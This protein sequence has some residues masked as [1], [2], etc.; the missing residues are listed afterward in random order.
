MWRKVFLQKAESVD[1]LEFQHVSQIYQSI[2]VFKSKKK[3]NN[4]ERTIKGKRVSERHD[5]NKYANGKM[6]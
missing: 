1:E 6:Y 2:R 5:R 3:K 4:E